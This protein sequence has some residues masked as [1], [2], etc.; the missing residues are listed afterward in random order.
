[1]V[2]EY[3]SDIKESHNTQTFL[4]EAD[5]IR[6]KAFNNLKRYQSN[7]KVISKKINVL[8]IYFN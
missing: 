6:T 1:M 2:K 8:K 5:K 4:K 3:P 7:K